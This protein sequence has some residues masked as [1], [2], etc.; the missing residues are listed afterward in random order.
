M[1][2]VH[3]RTKTLVHD[4]NEVVDKGGTILIS[5]H[6][7]SKRVAR[8]LDTHKRHMA[9]GAGSLI[10]SAAL[11]GPIGPAIQLSG[12]LVSF[13]VT[14][15]VQAVKKWRKAKKLKKF[16]AGGGEVTKSVSM[17]RPGKGAITVLVLNPDYM[18]LIED[19]R[20][21]LD[22]QQM[23]SLYNHFHNLERDFQRLSSRWVDFSGPLP[24][25]RKGVTNCT[26]AVD[27]YESIRR[28][29]FRYAQIR[30]AADM[31][32]DFVQGAVM[33]ISQ[34]EADRE[35]HKKLWETLTENYTAD[36]TKVLR[37]LSDVVNR[38]GY[39]RHLGRRMPGRLRRAKNY[40]SW[41]YFNLLPLRSILSGNDDRARVYDMR[42]FATAV[43]EGDDKFHEGMKSAFELATGSADWAFGGSIG[44]YTEL[45]QGLIEGD[46]EG[47]TDKLAEMSRDYTTDLGVE[48]ATFHAELAAGGHPKPVD[49]GGA[50]KPGVDKFTKGVADWLPGLV[51]FA[52]STTANAANAAW[53]KRKLR[54]KRTLGL[55]GMREQTLGERISTLRSFARKEAADY[56]KN[57]QN[58]VKALQ[59]AEQAGSPMAAAEALLAM[60]AAV[61]GYEDN[62]IG[63][64]LTEVVLET[65]RMVR[66]VEAVRLDALKSIDQ[67]IRNHRPGPCLVGN[68]CYGSLL[69]ALEG[70]MGTRVGSREDV[71]RTLDAIPC[72]SIEADNLGKVRRMHGLP[73]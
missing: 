44:A 5:K 1:T 52:A 19:V 32:A 15:G 34:C 26:D 48:Y 20:Y 27:L 57:V 9:I 33:V 11:T 38:K 37:I 7:R 72:C 65:E 68:Y 22:H 56:I 21:L 43:Q 36:P 58:G 17:E 40:G 31:L 25:L 53:N 62:K 8:Y 67:R 54:T 6:D 24:Q 28:V 18:D 13:S 73:A 12:K 30:E 64:L 50:F 23:T 70:T 10:T 16:T 49:P 39:R 61:K 4:I 66:G 69:E 42:I 35:L 47:V 29:Q 45:A 14:S 46:V 63:V 59:A 51:E 55:K 2:E 41:A 60:G 71:R 3:I